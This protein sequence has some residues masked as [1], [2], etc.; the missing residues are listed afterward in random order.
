MGDPGSLPGMGNYLITMVIVLAIVLALAVGFIHL[1]RRLAPRPAS[2]RAIRIIE[3]VALEP[4]RALHLV[5]IGTRILLLGSTDGS[6]GMLAEIDSEQ[7][8]LPEPGRSGS[9][10]FLDLIR[11]RRTDQ[12]E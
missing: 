4:R 1:M 6:V 10:R 7:V 11:G 3:S 9:G 12:S 8:D 5:Q 2:G